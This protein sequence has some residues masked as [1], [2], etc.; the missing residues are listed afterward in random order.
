MK[1]RVIIAL[2]SAY[3]Q[4]V[5]IQWAAE[6]LRILL[7]D[8]T[9]SKR[10]WTPDI[11]GTGKWYM[12][13]LVYATTTLSVDELQTALKEIEAST[14]RTKALI[15]IDLDL[16]QYDQQRYHEKD[17]QR[18]YIIRCLSSLPCYIFFTSD[19]RKFQKSL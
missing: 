7:D 6:R 18:D 12:N 3:L 5:H 13:R 16:M 8:C 14:G 2:G 4:A 15:T 10:L 9:F 1:H 17:W 19:I 11:K